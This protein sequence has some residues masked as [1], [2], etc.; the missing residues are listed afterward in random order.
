MR[1]LFPTAK[2]QQQQTPPTERPK[3]AESITKQTYTEKRKEK[4]PSRR[5]VSP[6]FLETKIWPMARHVTFF[7]IKI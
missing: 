2:E 3:T 7:E 6:R 5:L 4:N 1:K